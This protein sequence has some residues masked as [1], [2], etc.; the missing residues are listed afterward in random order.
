MFELFLI[1][2]VILFTTQVRPGV[3]GAIH[4]APSPN[5]PKPY[6]D[7]DGGA[8]PSHSAF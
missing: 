5:K 2:K 1:E 8:Q 4:A 6:A 3:S 7:A